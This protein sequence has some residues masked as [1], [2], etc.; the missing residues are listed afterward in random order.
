MITKTKEDNFIYVSI[1]EK[2]KQ[3]L[4]YVC[5]KLNISMSSFV[6][7]NTLRQ[8]RILYNE[9]KK[10]VTENFKTAQEVMKD[11]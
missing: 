11:G 4:R 10:P 9:F 5:K 8:A 1:S 7:Y 3:L 2:D 6:K